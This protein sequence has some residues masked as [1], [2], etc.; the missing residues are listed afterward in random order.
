[1]IWIN[2]DKKSLGDTCNMRKEK[3]T[4]IYKLNAAKLTTDND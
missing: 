2:E 4:G 3:V 1:M